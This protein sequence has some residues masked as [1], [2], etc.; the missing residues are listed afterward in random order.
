VRVAKTIEEVRAD[1]GAYPTHLLEG[2]SSALVLFAAAFQGRN[3]AIH[4]L[5]ADIFDVTCVDSD[6]DALLRMSKLYPQVWDF[7]CEDAFKL[8]TEADGLLSWDV[9]S[10]DTFTGKATA[11][12][13]ALLD[14]WCFLA[15][16]LVTCTCTRQDFGEFRT[17]EGWTA[18]LHH[19]SGDVYWLVLVPHET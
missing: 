1:A 14:R 12:A 15:R 13:L 19:R 9:V 10:V 18:K 2:C 7:R 17:P 5:D 11:L 16:K 6:E 8:A 4:M 3:D